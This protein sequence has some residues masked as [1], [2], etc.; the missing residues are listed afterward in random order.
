MDPTWYQMELFI[1]LYIEQ[2]PYQSDLFEACVI[3]EVSG[4]L[5]DNDD[6]PFSYP[7]KEKVN[8]T[9]KAMVGLNVNDVDWL[10]LF[11]PIPREELEKMYFKMKIYACDL[12]DALY[13]DE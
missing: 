4:T 11:E 3:R 13:F 6:N 2:N 8:L 7:Q 1:N 9:G 5:L 10:Q 12:D